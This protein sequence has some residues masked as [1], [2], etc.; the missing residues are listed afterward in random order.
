MLLVYPQFVHSYRST[1][2]WY[3][4]SA[5]YPGGRNLIAF[6]KVR[7]V[8]LPVRQTY[9]LEWVLLYRDGLQAY[10]NRDFASA[11]QIFEQALAVKGSPRYPEMLHARAY[12]YSRI[13]PR[14]VPLRQLDSLLSLDSLC[15]GA[16]KDL[17]ID[18][19]TTG[20]TSQARIQRHWLAQHCP[21][22]LR[23]LD[24]AVVQGARQ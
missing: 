14:E 2:W 16:H 5:Y 23:R 1:S 15:E 24:A 3:K 4:D 12:C 19:G 9:P 13:A 17:Y 6:K 21:W 22:D 18:A 11:L 20:D 10:A 8:K 7:D